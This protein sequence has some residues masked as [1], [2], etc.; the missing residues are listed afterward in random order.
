MTSCVGDTDTIAH[1]YNIL[2]T[3]SKN[4]RGY[5]HIHTQFMLTLG[6]LHTH[7]QQVGVCEHTHFCAHSVT[8][9]HTPWDFTDTQT[10]LLPHRHFQT[11]HKYFD[12]H[13]GTHQE[14]TRKHTVTHVTHS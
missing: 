9:T 1:T 8:L 11:L 13:I 5:V 3:D 2:Y 12:G 6:T 10:H 4:T 14:F 7:T